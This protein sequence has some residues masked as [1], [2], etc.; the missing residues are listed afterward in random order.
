MTQSNEFSIDSEVG[1]NSNYSHRQNSQSISYTRSDN[2]VNNDEN[3]INPPPSYEESIVHALNQFQFTS[4]PVSLN[5][6]PI[7]GTNERLPLL[8]N[9]SERINGDPLNSTYYSTID[10]P[11]INELNIL[12]DDLPNFRVPEVEFD[13]LE[14]G[15]S[16]S[17]S[18]LNKDLGSLFEFF[19]EHNDKPE[20]A[21][22]IQGYRI[23]GHGNGKHR[24]NIEIMD[25]KFTLDLTEYVSSHGEI[26]AV[27]TE[28]KPNR[29]VIQALEEYLQR[30]SVWKGIEMRKVVNWDYET[31]TK[32][33][34]STIRQQGYR[35]Q[36][37]ISYPSRNNVVR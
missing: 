28:N 18:R 20:M 24:K 21:I 26:R 35:R 32:V 4:M 3:S 23:H 16:S 12:R 11:Q 6:R 15:V 10:S 9:T 37:R 27:P 8:K 5:S 36:I 2:D 33:I 25:F 13:L 19:I 34:V 22:I 17:D 14:N 1:D 7:Q 31:I 30:D 29:N